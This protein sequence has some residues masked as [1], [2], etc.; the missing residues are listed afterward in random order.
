MVYITQETSYIHWPLKAAY[1][2]IKRLCWHVS[3]PANVRQAN[4]RPAND[5]Q[6]NV[7]QANVRHANV[8]QANVRQANV[9]QANV[10]PANGIK[11]AI[12]VV[13]ICEKKKKLHQKIQSEGCYTIYSAVERMV[14]DIKSSMRS[15]S[16]S[17][18]CNEGLRMVV[19]EPV[20]QLRSRGNH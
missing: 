5:R 2:P 12:E 7:R 18:F 10:G 20:C 15:S 16:S 14:C 19:V 8:R 13:P 6:A 1:W 17:T 11:Y 9:R 3:R 4:V